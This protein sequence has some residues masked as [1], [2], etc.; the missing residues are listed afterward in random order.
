METIIMKGKNNEDMN[1]K[2]MNSKEVHIKHT[3]NENK[4]R[5]RGLS[6]IGLLWGGMRK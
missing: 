5:R 4:C 1:L 2:V 3:E 6:V